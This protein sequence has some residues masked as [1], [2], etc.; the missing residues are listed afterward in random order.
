MGEKTIK[1][2]VINYAKNK[3]Y[4]HINDLKEYFIE[5]KF[6]YKKS[7]LKQSLYLFKKE[8]LI[9]EAGKGWYSTIKE[10]FELDKSPLRK[11]AKLIK[12]KFPLLK[13]S[14]WTTKQLKTFFH[15]LPNQFVTFVYSDKDSLQFLKDHLTENGYNV[16]LNPIKSETKKYVELYNRTIILRPSIS[17]REPKTQYWAKI[18]KIIVDLYMETKKVNLIDMEEYK[19]IMSN[20]ILNYRINIAEMFDYAHNRKVEDRIQNIMEG[21]C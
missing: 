21:I 2:H 14:C 8:K 13:F 4:F 6:K 1:E 11:I 18:E 7:S 10:K 15:H 9:Y 17:Y 3:Y 20:I 19:K 5:R 16:Y 12:N